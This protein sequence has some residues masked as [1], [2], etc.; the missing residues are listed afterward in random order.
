MPAAG[1]AIAGPRSAQELGV[2]VL[3]GGPGRRL[4]EL[5]AT[6]KDFSQT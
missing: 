2:P 6:A 4:A 5:L 3:V 1:A